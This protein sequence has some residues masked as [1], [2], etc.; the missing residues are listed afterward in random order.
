MKYPVCSSRLAAAEMTVREDLRE[1]ANVTCCHRLPK[2]QEAAFPEVSLSQPQPPLY[3]VL[4][5]LLPLRYFSEKRV[6]GLE[7]F[8]RVYYDA[9]R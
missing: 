6:N 3:F 2:R 4:E 1:G 9:G 8:I 5:L 7:A